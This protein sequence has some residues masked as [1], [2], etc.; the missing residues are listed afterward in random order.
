ML[1]FVLDRHTIAAIAIAGSGLDVLGALYLAYDLL[2]GQHGPLRTLTRAVT[3]GVLFALGYG[4]GLGVAFGIATGLTH[5]VTLAWEFSRAARGCRDGSPLSDIAVS[6]IRGL[7]FGVGMS[8]TFGPVFGA[9]FGSLSAIGQIVA[10]HFG[11]RPT[12]DYHP[13]TRP[14]IS[15]RQILAGLNRAVG[16][17]VATWIAAAASDQQSHVMPLALRAGLTV[18]AVTAL[19]ILFTPLI[20]WMAENIPE[21]RLAVFGLFLILCGFALQSVQY[22]VV[23]LDVPVR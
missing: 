23:V 6:C 2:G 10:Y 4:L 12:L 20:E 18:G 16:Y 17:L 5:A 8:W 22:W 1:T 13:Q 14:R 11:I 3:Y 21:K 9:V 19:M 7:G 15:R